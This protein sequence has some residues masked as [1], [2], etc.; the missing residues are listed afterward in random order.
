MPNYQL[1]KIYQIV[2]DVNNKVYVGST[3]Q[4]LCSR[5]AC[6]RSEGKVLRRKTPMY[7]SMHET[8]VEHFR[9]LLVQNA[10][11]N[12]KEELHAIEYSV[13]RQFQQRGVILYNSIIDGRCSEETRAK[14]RGRVVSEETRAK[15]RGRVVSEQTR[16]K[17]S[18]AQKGKVMSAE[19]RVKMS[20]ARTNKGCVRF[21]NG[22][23]CWSFHWCQDGRQMNRYFS[24][25]KYGF[26]GAHG[27]ALFHQEEM[28]PLERDDDS[29]FIQ[30][31]KNRLNN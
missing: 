22:E 14:L 27:L 19:A 13:M 23:N 20:K 8:G 11:C 28:Y 6:H 1:G 5:M 10:P 16:A 30:E 17:M 15:L 3:C 31:I 25:K 2:N 12:T 29:E 21:N 26:N 4:S 7:L 9:I 24:V 18:K